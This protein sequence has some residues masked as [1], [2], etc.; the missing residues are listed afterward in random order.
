MKKL[1]GIIVLGLLLTGCFATTGKYEAALESWVGG[2]EDA[3]VS[4]WGAP[5]GVYDK[6]DGGRVLTYFR[7]YQS[8]YEGTTS[9]KTTVD[10]WGQATTTTSTTPGTDITLTCKT[11]FV[12]SSIGRITSWSYQ[13][14]DC[15]S[16]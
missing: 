7:S 3:L 12:V 2:S 10:A 14:N 13:G 11:T 1:L 8:T 5:N 15:T 16:R 9:T 4:S 6:N